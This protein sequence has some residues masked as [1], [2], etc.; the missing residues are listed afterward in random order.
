[1]ISTSLSQG[2]S[3]GCLVLKSASTVQVVPMSKNYSVTASHPALASRDG[4]VSFLVTTVRIFIF[5]VLKKIELPA[6]EKRRK[7]QRPK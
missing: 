4:A 6:L 3:W 2:K 5:Q 7:R 1:M